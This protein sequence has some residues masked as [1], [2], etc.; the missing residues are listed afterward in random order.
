MLCNYHKMGNRNGIPILRDEDVNLLS[1]SSGVSEEEVRGYY[2]K[3]VKQHGGR[4][5]ERDFH[6]ML[7]LVSF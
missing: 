7:K 4:L 2:E 1:E 5:K 3:F 6:K